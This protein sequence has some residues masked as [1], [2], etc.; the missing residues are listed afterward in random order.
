VRSSRRRIREWHDGS[1]GFTSTVDVVDLLR[2]AGGF[3][4]NQQRRTHG[5]A[6]VDAGAPRGAVR[7]RA[8]ADLFWCL[9]GNKIGVEDFT[10]PHI[11]RFLLECF[12]FVQM[13]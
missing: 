6:D 3:D 13:S 12:F 7:L 10:P 9:N 11:D 8:D 4:R 1:S 2:D 5:V